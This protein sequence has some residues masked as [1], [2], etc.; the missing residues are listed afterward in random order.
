MA[1]IVDAIRLMRQRGARRVEVRPEVQEA[2]V[3][4]AEARSVDTVWLHG[5]CRSY[6]QTPDGRNA[7]LWPNWSFRYRQRTRRFDAEAFVVEPA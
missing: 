3:S 6:Y 5:G 2:F 7:G 4:E 1:Y